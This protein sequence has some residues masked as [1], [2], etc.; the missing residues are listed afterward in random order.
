MFKSEEIAGGSGQYHDYCDYALIPVSK[1]GETK[2]AG[3]DPGH[4]KVLYENGEGYGHGGGG[5]SGGD[6]SCD[7]LVRKNGQIYYNNKTYPLT[8]DELRQNKHIWTSS[9]YLDL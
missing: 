3:Y 6:G 1:A 2:L 4:L 8:L 5:N 9:D 7:E